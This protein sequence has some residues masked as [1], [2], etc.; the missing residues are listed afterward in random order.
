MSDSNRLRHF[1][2]SFFPIVLGLS[3]LALVG[4]KV[5]E[6]YPALEPLALALTVFSLA[7]FA[8]VSV[9][10]L[11]RFLRYPDAVRSEFMH[12]VKM[13]FFPII[14]KIF[15]I[16]SVIFLSIDKK[17][18]LV[19]WTIGVAIQTVLMFVIVST[20]IRHTKFEIHHMNPAWFMPVVGAIIIPIAGVEH[21]QQAVSWFFF[22]V[23]IVLWLALFTIVLYRM[24]FHAPMAN[25]LLPTLFILFAPPAI[26]F[27]SYYKLTGS[28]DS[29]ALV[30]FNLSLFLFVLVLFQAGLFAKIKFY[31]SWWAYTFP[32]SAMTVAVLLMF[33]VSGDLA[34]KYLALTLASALA[35]IAAFLA[36]RT[37]LGVARKELCVEE[38][39]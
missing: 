39:E 14:A 6:L 11:A 13:N 21:G 16:H 36:L 2:I 28:L 1:S 26:G 25:R 3:G 32:L 35:L 7:A 10:Y 22:S 8:A 20:W 4:V 33:R 37:S 17:T 31:L 19:L 38:R 23:G 5:G 18:S 30:L 27:I 9:L 12:P 15:L 24:I 29:F 34:W